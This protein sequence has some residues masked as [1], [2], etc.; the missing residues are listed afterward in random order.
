MYLLR[1][2]RHLR[3][4]TGV[5][6][7]AAVAFAAVGL[8]LFDGWLAEVEKMAPE[9]ALRRLRSVFVWVVGSGGVAVI[10]LAIHLW[11]LGSRV[12]AVRQFP[13]PRARALRDT[14]VMRDAAA[15]R[16]GRVIQAFAV[17]LALCGAGL[18]GVGWR[19]YFVFA[20]H[21]A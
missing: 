9:A 20:P 12:R 3:V 2:D 5:A 7:L 16:R 8:W 4:V 18:L 10:A 11:N 14:V 21:A 6:L 15:V 13:L 1:A 19:L 17:A